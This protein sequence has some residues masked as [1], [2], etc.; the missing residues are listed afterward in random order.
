MV[1]GSTPAARNADTKTKLPFDFDIFSPSKPTIPL[2][3]YAR[4]KG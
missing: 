3:R 4:A 2:C 1:I